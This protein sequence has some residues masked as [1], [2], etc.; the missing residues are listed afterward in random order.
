MHYIVFDMEFAV[1]RQKRHTA[2]ILEIGAIKLND[3]SGT[4]AMVDLFQTHVRPTYFT[5]ITP[6]TTEFTGITQKQADQAP[7][8]KEA[9][10]RF[11]SWLG[12]S[13]YFMCSWGPDDKHQLVRQCRLHR[14]G[15]DWIQNYNDIQLMFT[16]L[17]G[18]DHGQRIGLKKALAVSGMDFVGNHHNALDDAFNTAKL[19]KL[20][21]P[22]LRLE[23][24][25]AATE[26]PNASSLV[27]TTGESVNRPF[28]HLAKLLRTTV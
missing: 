22:R 5:T 10:S 15:L 12:A 28:K 11:Q 27:Y 9:V 4:L 20:I 8:F 21:F 24:N 3:E 1:M 26:R 6:L 7:S 23:E 17:Q 25:N 2:E 14:I 13:P 19:F 16:R 18:A